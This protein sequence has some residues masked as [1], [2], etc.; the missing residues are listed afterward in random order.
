[1]I[2]THSTYPAIYTLVKEI[3]CGEVA[4]YKMV[5]SLVKGS[6]A[7]IVGS[8][9]AAVPSDAGVPWHRVI[10]SAG[11][12]S[13]REGSQRQRD[14][15]DAEGVAFTK[16]G[17]VDWKNHRWNGPSETWLESAGLDFIDFLTIQSNWPG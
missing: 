15:L 2:R 7:R 4:S 9:M 5:S 8:A 17:K 1:M 11:K 6:T 3:P 14:R 16:G 10:N 13:V 12:I